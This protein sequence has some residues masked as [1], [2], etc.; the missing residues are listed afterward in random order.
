MLNVTVAWSNYSVVIK[1][2]VAL[3]HDRKLMCT[4][5]SDAWLGLLR[6]PLPSDLLKKV[7]VQ[8]HSKV[9]P[10]LANPL[11]LSDFL[12]SCLDQGGLLGMLALNGL[13][14]LVTKHG[15]E[16]PHFYVR[17]YAL[18]QVRGTAGLPLQCVQGICHDS[19]VGCVVVSLR[20]GK[21]KISARGT[22]TVPRCA[23]RALFYLH[24]S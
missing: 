4:H 12:S 21:S 18:L 19:Y 3:M 14:T 5:C 24:A 2:L 13:F 7:L 16:Y 15:L 10:S 20:V 17:L 6:L 8:L 11:L 23:L 22:G 1:T 9:M